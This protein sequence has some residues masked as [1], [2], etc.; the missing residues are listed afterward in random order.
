MR[1]EQSHCRAGSPEC[2]AV[3]EPPKWYGV[4]SWR[5]AQVMAVTTAGGASVGTALSV[6]V[7]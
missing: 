1:D 3:Q 5:M 7:S 2:G 4:P 6:R